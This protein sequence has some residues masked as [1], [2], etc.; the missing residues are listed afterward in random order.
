MIK[1]KEYIKAIVPF[2]DKPVIKAISGIRRC[3]KSTLLHQIIESLMERGIAAEQIIYIN[4]EL[5]EFDEIKNY[6]QL[7]NYISELSTSAGKKYYVFIDEVQEIEYWE[8]TINSLLAEGNYDLF[9]TGSNAR[10]LS[11]ELATFLAGRYVEFRMQTLGYSEFREI[12]N[13]KNHQSDRD[14]FNLFLKYGGFPGIHH[15]AMDDLVVRQYLQSIYNTVLLKDVVLRNKIRDVPMLDSI[16][17]YLIDNC[18]NIT[19][20]TNISKFMKS[21]KRPVAVD[22]VLNYV[23]YLCDAMAFAQIKRYD[24][25]GK[26][27]LETNEKYFLGDIGF[28][29]ATLGY[30]PEAIAGQLENIVLLEL[31]ARNYKVSFGKIEEKEIDFIA[32][33]GSEK[34]YIQVCNSLS[35]DKVIDREYSSLNEVDDHFPKIVLSMDKGFDTTRNGIRWMNIEDFLLE[36]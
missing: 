4:K 25:K 34:I 31:K 1:R 22:T 10:F 33:R 11:S 14:D 29:Y 19:S 17:K 7:H 9:I 12:L 26:R 15:L 5:F 30:T 36:K 24:I 21:Q 35:D 32:E 23:S 18:G 13:V 6:K 16:T 8:K 2:I 3:G 28:R 20:A 27:L